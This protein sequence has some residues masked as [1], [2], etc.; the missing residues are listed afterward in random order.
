[1]T[2][3]MEIYVLVLIL[4]YFDINET[5]II[6]GYSTA[7]IAINDINPKSQIPHFSNR[8]AYHCKYFPG[9]ISNSQLVSIKYLT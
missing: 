2:I 3:P 9:S 7:T 1:M 5:R 8:T 6:N 4:L